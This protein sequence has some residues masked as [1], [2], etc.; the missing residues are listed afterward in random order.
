MLQR[1]YGTVFTKKSE[2]DTY[3]NMLEEAKKR[4]HRKLGK[5]LKLFTLME[6][7]PGFPF[8]LPNGVVLKNNLI[9]YWRGLHKK[10]G[11]VEI[12]TPLIL[13]RKLWETSGHW[14]HYKENM[15][16]VNID[17]EDELAS[18][19][20]IMSIPCVI[21]FNDGVEGNRLITYKRGFL[22]QNNK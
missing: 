8:F 2:L 18:S 7:G 14:D 15:Y 20:G 22:F 9:D 19:L 5:E 13:N 6:E 16:T 10:S 17:E 11:Y 1:I 4:D 21:M 12:E 3:L